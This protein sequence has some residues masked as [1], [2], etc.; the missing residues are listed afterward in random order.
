MY[1]YWSVSAVVYDRF[2]VTLTSL[3][4]RAVGVLAVRRATTDDNDENQG[5][6]DQHDGTASH[7]HGHP[8]D[9]GRPTTRQ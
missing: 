9:G 4:L 7:G 6:R 3:T 1:Y 2:H 8:G 5:E